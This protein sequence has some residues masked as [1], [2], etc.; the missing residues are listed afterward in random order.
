[1]CNRMISQTAWPE[2]WS[3]AAADLCDILIMAERFAETKNTG[4]LA[5]DLI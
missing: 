3:V 5:H 1:M 2:S 4:N